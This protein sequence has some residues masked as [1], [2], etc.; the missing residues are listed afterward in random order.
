MIRKEGELLL[1][2]GLVENAFSTGAN[3]RYLSSEFCV[4]LDIH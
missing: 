1:L 3:E 2:M 4:A